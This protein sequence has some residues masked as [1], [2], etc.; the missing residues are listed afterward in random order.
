MGFEFALK[1][2]V[3]AL[4]GNAITRKG[5]ADD[6]HRQFANTRKSLDPI[7]ELIREG[8]NL[9]I[10]HGNG[11]QVGNAL[12]RVE[13]AKD[14][15]PFVPL[16]VLV[17]DT[18]G[19]MGYMIAQS[20]E[21]RLKREGIHQKVCTVITQVIVD[22]DDPSIKNPTKFIGQFYSEEEARKLASQLNWVVKDDAGRGWRRVVPSPKP[23]D[24]VEGV[25]IR[26]LVRGG[27]IVIAAGG[28]GIPVYVE[29][30]G[31][32]EGVDAV[33]DKDYASA[34]LGNAIGAELLIIVTNIDKVY[35]NFGSPDQKP[36]DRIAVG[37]MEKLLHQG[38]FP[39]GSMG[40]KVSAAIKFIKGGGKKV[41]ITSIENAYS[42]VAGSTGTIIF[43]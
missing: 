27:V 19:S 28:G 34:V 20:L 31:T 41:V 3:V 11:P 23:L 26:N 8:Y 39:Y 7:V 6:I 14:I 5:E 15:T 17:A 32:Y 36:L 24:I 1:T 33:V 12:L 40:P 18:Q 2:A 43:A 37:E 29:N 35:L 9:A 16:G 38:H 21:N 22:R 25:I 10:S 42:A 13:L 30:D 4:G